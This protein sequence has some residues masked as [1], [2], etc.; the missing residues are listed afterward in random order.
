MVG[1]LGDAQINNY[2][3]TDHRTTLLRHNLQAC[4][5]ALHATPCPVAKLNR[6]FGGLMAVVREERH[7][8]KS[9]DSTRDGR[10]ATCC[11]A[12]IVYGGATRTGNNQAQSQSQSGGPCELFFGLVQVTA[13]CN[14]PFSVACLND[15]IA[16]EVYSAGSG[17][18]APAGT[19]LSFFQYL[20][21]C[22][23][24]STYNCTSRLRTPA[25]LQARPMRVCA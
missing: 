13:W 19:F 8:A 6:A 18:Y 24:T 23:C 9:V 4:M 7:P 20:Q 10:T 16:L 21:S 22:S 17:W 11:I 3:N 2:C 1:L 14:Q 15:M 12:W 25:C 5:Q